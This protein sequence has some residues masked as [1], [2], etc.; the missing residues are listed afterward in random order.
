MEPRILLIG[1][2]LPVLEKMEDS[3]KSAGRSIYIANSKVLVERNLSRQKIDLVTIGA[4]MDDDTRNDMVDFIRSRKPDMPIHLLE[5]KKENTVE[6][7]LSFTT[8][9]AL[10]W[11][12]KNAEAQK[13]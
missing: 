11:K 7:F 6:E 10:E 4:G 9:I 8:E 1:K 2:T 3:L 12:L 13:A 5:R